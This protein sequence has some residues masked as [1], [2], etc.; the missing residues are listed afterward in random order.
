M[1]WLIGLCGL[2]GLPLLMLADVQA[3][4]RGSG[5]VRCES[6]DMARVHCDMDT[7][8]GVQLVRQLSETSCIRGSEWDIERDGVWV[9][10]GCRAE[11]ASARVL[12]TPQM[13]RVVRC[14]SNGSKVACPVILRGAP[15][16]LLRQR[17]VWPCKE[18]RSW[19]TRRNEIWVSRGCDGEFEVGAEDGSGFV[20]MPRTLTCESKSRS[21]R[22]CGVSVERNVRLRKQISGSPCVEGQTWGWSRDGV[23]VNDGCR[24]EFIVD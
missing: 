8:H 11:F 24:A 6:K 18:G 23:W 21:R 2:W 20:D 5:V 3:A 15:V 13:R 14:D 7:E 22:M 19:G 9:E 1:K 17:S 16:R 4:E 10:Q 12:A